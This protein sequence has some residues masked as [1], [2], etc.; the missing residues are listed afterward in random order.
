MGVVQLRNERRTR[1]QDMADEVRNMCRAYSTD[2]IQCLM[3]ICVDETHPANAR[4]TAATYI[5]DRAFGKPTQA[6][7]H[8]GKGGDPLKIVLAGHDANL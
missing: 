4:V 8:N 2:A 5:V 3:D 7:E 6:L 1:E